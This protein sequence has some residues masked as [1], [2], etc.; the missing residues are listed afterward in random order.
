M[1]AMPEDPYEEEIDRDSEQ[2]LFMT[3]WI[4]EIS[5]FW[6]APLVLR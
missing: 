6:V 5:W 2:V 4:L 1:D 3:L